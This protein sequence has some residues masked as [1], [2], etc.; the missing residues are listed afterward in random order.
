[1]GV[2]RQK[3]ITARSHQQVL[4]HR[5]DIP[6][7]L[8]RLTGNGMLPMKSMPVADFRRCQPNSVSGPL[9]TSDAGDIDLSYNSTSV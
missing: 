8:I 5:D 9:L 4:D 1:M 7:V 3:W 2:T 6:T